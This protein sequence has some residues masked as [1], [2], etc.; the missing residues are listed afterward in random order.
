MEQAIGE[1]MR[2]LIAAAGVTAALAFAMPA[3]AQDSTM[4]QT[5]PANAAPSSTTSNAT[6]NNPTV[7]R[8]TMAPD[9]TAGRFRSDNVGRNDNVGS[10]N[11]TPS[12]A[13]GVVNKNDA[14][15]Q[16]GTKST[17]Q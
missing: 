1:N 2:H 13:D 8:N 11:T 6:A 9:P 16:P 3:F 5:G 14:S 12:T 17:N 10:S 15:N 7:A 4:I